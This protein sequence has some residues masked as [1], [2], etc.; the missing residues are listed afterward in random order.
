MEDF[1]V[2][3]ETDEEI[4][5]PR[6]RKRAPAGKTGNARGSVPSSPPEV[7]DEELD[8]EIPTRSTAQ[9]W[10]Y[11][12]DNVAPL[13]PPKATNGTK[14]STSKNVKQKAHVTEPE[15]RYPWL[16]NVLDKDRNPPGHP[17]YDP[18]TIFVPPMAWNGFSPF[19]KQYW[20]IKQ[21]FWDTIVFFKKG[22][23]YELYENDA[24]VGHQMFD[25]KLTDRV[26]MRM[27]GV[28]E[29]S[30]D[31]WA[32]Q[33]VAKGFKIARV[34]QM[35]SALAKEMR[36]R[37]DPSGKKTKTK[38]KGEDKIIR[39]E[40]AAVLTAGTLVDSGML[41]D[42]MSTFCAAIKEIEK[43]GLPAFGIAF[44]DAA[45]AQFQLCEFTD[46]ADMTKFETFVAQT[47]PGE[48]LL[49]KVC[50]FGIHNLKIANANCN[51][52]HVYQQRLCEYSRTAP[53]LQPSGTTSDLERSSGQL[54]SRVVKSTPA[55]ISLLRRL[56]MELQRTLCGPLLLNKQRKKRPSCLPL[57]P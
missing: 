4:A 34:D 30:L 38:A 10:A 55:V 43:D 19:E 17:D 54:T 2:A 20:E 22:K 6:K 13:N 16:A 41:Q 47:R 56:M 7:I 23:F 25:L 1:I 9:Q 36:E 18:R 50:F 42:D 8:M 26:N 14:S 57:V 33:F 37:D 52:S 31:H 21:N 3:D 11:D 45:T 48:L 44:V 29:A 24:T 40:L 15:K 32:N 39:R 5:K 28:P 53:V 49:E 27:V 51:T 12:P 35:E 46:D